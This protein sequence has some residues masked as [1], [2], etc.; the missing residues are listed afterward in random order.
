VYVED[1]ADFNAIFDVDLTYNKASWVV[2]ML[3]G[4]L[5]DEDFFAGLLHYR[6]LYG[7]GTANTEQLRDA[8]EDVSGRDLDAFFQQWI[9]G[10]YYPVY[11]VAWTEA[12]GG[13]DVVVE[14]IQTNTGLFTMPI[15]VRVLT[16]AGAFDF[17]VENAAATESYSLAVPGDVEDVLLDPDRWILRSVESVVANPTFDDG[18]LLVNG[19]DWGTYGTEITSAYA[20][21]AFWGDHAISFWDTFAEP[22]GGYPANLPAPVGHGAVSAGALGGYST[23]LWVGN[24]FGGDLVDWT[25]TPI[26]SYLDVG[27]NVLLMTRMGSDFLAGGLQSYAGITWNGSQV[28]LTGCTAVY[29]GLGNIAFTGSQSLNDTFSM[30]LGP[31]ST[32][33]FRDTATRGTGVHA[34]PP[35]GGT[36]RPDGGRLIFLAGRPYRMNHAQLRTDVEFLLEHFFGEPYASPAPEVAAVASPR[37]E[38]APNRPNPFSR[39]TLI[40]F[41]LPAAGSADVSVYDVAGRLVK[42]LVRG[43]QR[44][45]DRTV[46]WDA[47]DD[48][49]RR[50]APGTYFVRLSDGT[51][52]VSRS[53]VVLR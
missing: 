43:P 13:V 36:H 48:R 18:I 38:L 26:Q 31:N 8:M 27:G 39:E 7:G 34:Q 15:Q 12:S 28:T 49:G 5:G 6:A 41:S 9:Y 4:V 53:V 24:N 23:V 20:D 16:T 11:R 45:G 10:E 44:A 32:L 14:Q 37:F 30:T 22:A 52:A 17:V 33:L 3:R 2:H 40:P 25:E 42:G 29:P 19:V 35:G 47:R 51:R 1:T 50:V 46:A 21:S